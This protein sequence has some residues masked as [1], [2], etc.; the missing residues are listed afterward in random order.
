M[1]YDNNNLSNIALSSF[2]TINET[3]MNIMLN[4]YINLSN[5]NLSSFKTKNVANM[6][7]MF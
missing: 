6:D 7:N 2:D 4:N 5:I 3:N 1:F